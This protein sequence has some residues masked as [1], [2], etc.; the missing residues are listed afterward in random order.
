VLRWL[1]CQLLGSAE[2]TFSIKKFQVDLKS[3]GVAVGK[4]TLHRS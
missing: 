1:V 4:D 2:G 3:Q